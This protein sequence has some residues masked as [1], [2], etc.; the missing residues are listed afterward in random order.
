MRLDDQRYTVR[1]HSE[2]SLDETFERSLQGKGKGC[3][4]EGGN[5]RR[6]AAC[7]L[8]RFHEWAAN[9][10]GGDDWTGTLLTTSTP[11]PT[12]VN[13]NARVFCEYAR[14]LAGDQRC[15]TVVHS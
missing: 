8:A 9:E 14:Y 12:F 3:S 10:R 2:R 5:Y 7:E 11:I 15:D 6:N 4:G 13:L 1:A